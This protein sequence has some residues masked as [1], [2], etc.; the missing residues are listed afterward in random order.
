MAYAYRWYMDEGGE[1]ICGPDGLDMGD[2]ETIL[3]E[4]PGGE[5]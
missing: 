2:D 4:I 5:S 1:M 3:I